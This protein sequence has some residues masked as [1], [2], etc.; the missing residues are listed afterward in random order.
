MRY[1]NF[2]L[3][4]AVLDGWKR[5]AWAWLTGHEENA[6]AETVARAASSRV[7]LLIEALR[8]PKT[9]EEW[10][11]MV[12]ALDIEPEPCANEVEARERQKFPELKWSHGNPVS[13]HRRMV[14]DWER[15]DDAWS[16]DTK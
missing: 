4:D 11:V 8:N 3:T 16:E 5:D 7:E 6:D 10:G 2:V 9:T 13:L 12:P 14:T 1:M 15:V